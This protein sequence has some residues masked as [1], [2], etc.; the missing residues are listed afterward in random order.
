MANV[1]CEEERR[2]TMPF[3]DLAEIHLHY[4]LEGDES[5]PVLTLS[6]SLS[7]DLDMWTPQMAAFI[8][9]FRV[10]RYDT[11]GHGQSGVPAGP[12]SFAQLGADV[13]GL[14]DHLGIERSHFCGLS[15]G[16][17][18]GMWLGIHQPQRIHRLVLCNT[19]AYIA[20][21]EVWSGRIATVMASG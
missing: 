13:I 4:S 11:R 7:I 12:Y 10:L 16:G 19:A 9:H 6:N 17:I 1:V 14:F 3:A 18:T 8:K 20:P 2:T 5:R 15:M 21:R